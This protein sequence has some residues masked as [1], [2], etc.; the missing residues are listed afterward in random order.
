MST[1]L[2]TIKNTGKQG[3]EMSKDEQE[4]MLKTITLFD[5]F[6]TTNR[7]KKANL[8]IT[9]ELV[10]IARWKNYQYGYTNQRFP[11]TGKTYWVRIDEVF[12]LEVNIT[13]ILSQSKLQELED[14]IYTLLNVTKEEK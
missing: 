6:H 12:L 7:G 5:Y 13:D 10:K 11:P 14:S 1:D 8:V 4:Q 3:A 9:Y 2:A